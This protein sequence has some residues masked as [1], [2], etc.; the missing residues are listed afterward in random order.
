MKTFTLIHVVVGLDL[1]SK[2]EVLLT[3]AVLE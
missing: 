1:N 2:T 3:A